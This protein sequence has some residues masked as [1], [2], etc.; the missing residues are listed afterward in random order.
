[1]SLRRNERGCP[2]PTKASSTAPLPLFLAE[3]LKL[4]WEQHRQA[5][6][7]HRHAGEG[8]G[9]RQVTPMTSTLHRAS[10]LHSAMEHKEVISEEFGIY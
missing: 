1:M 6:Q 9:G 7:G 8:A 4:L 3:V 5:R 2:I 10:W